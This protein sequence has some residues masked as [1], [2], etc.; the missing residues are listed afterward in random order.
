[1]SDVSKLSTNLRRISGRFG[2]ASSL[3]SRFRRDFTLGGVVRGCCDF[4]PP[5]TFC[6]PGSFSVVPLWRIFRGFRALF[7]FRLS[8]L[9][10]CGSSFLVCSSP[11]DRLHS[12][13][14]A[15]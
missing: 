6:T 14:T 1:M 2:V 7:E 12:N 9:E 11:E 4:S 8:I 3:V 10:V 13:S 15:S 5:I